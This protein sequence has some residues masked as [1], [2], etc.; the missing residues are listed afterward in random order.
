MRIRYLCLFVALVATAGLCFGQGISVI[1][2]YLPPEYGG[3][4]ALT[5]PLCGS[6]N[7]LP[8]GTWIEIRWDMDSDGPDAE[9]PLPPLCNNPPLCEDGPTGSFNRQGFA[10]NG[11]A[12]GLGE[13]WFAMESGFA[14]V[15]VA[16]TPSRFYLVIRCPLE[17][18]H[19]QSP[20]YEPAVGGNEFFITATDWSCLP[21]MSCEGTP[22]FTISIPS[23]FQWCWGCASSACLQVCGGETTIIRICTNDGGH[24]EP[25][26]PPI[27]YVV[28]GCEINFTNCDVEC[29][30]AQFQYDPSAWVLNATSDCWI[31]VIHGVTDGCVCFTDEWL[32]ATI[33]ENSFAAIPGDNLVELEWTSLAEAAVESY[34][35]MR[36]GQRVSSIEAEN[37]PVGASYRFRDLSVVNGTT[38]VYTLHVVNLDNTEE[39]TGLEVT[40]TPHRGLAVIT[41]YA[42]HQNYPNPF[43]PETQ[44][45]FD[46]LEHGFA[47]LIVYDLMGREVSVLVNRDLNAGRH[48]ISFDAAGLPSGVY[49]YEFSVN[50]FTAQNKMLLLK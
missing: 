37:S 8:D 17:S 35:V 19:Y 36:D 26:R 13:G 49:L 28:P 38:Y 39:E 23:W 50:G 20:V 5:G 40:A 7:S 46:L 45:T 32:A 16:P 10:M 22:E 41:E 33:D 9:D 25:S 14:S 2:Y 3:G 6:G 27:T 48:T 44:I 43:N 34:V 4:P 11:S 1:W 31:N 42:L 21:C 15:G 47:S 18:V 29:P 24:F 12:Q 30:P